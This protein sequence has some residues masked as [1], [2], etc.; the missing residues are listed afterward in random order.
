MLEIDAPFNPRSSLKRRR[1]RVG[2]FGPSRPLRQLRESPL[3]Q[4][5]SP[6]TSD[7]ERGELRLHGELIVR[8]SAILN[9]SADDLLGIAPARRDSGTPNRRLRRQLQLIDALPKRDQEA[10][11]RTIDAFLSKGRSMSAP[12]R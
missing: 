12:Q 4:R 8:L 7:Y 2:P 9:V 5:L 1:L 3:Q 6:T 11:L 10:L